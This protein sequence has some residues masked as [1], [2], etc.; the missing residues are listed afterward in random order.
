MSCRTQFLEQSAAGTCWPHCL[1]SPVPS[2]TLEG[3][4][5]LLME[6]CKKHF[7]IAIYG[8]LIVNNYDWLAKYRLVVTCLCGSISIIVTLERSLFQSFTVINLK[9]ASQ[10]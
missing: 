9:D 4:G 10:T 2:D 6:I 3:G 1:P 7:E 8:N 5:E